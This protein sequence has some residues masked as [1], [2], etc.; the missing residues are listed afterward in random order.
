MFRLATQPQSIGKV[1]DSGLRLYMVSF[2]GV[3]GF[4]IGAGV[5][6]VIP[7]VVVEVVL[8]QE[9]TTENI[10]IGV[11]SFLLAFILLSI[12]LYGAI[13]VRM[14]GVT[15][16]I[17]IRFIQAIMI[18][19]KRLP[20]LLLVFVLYGIA[21]VL[22]TLLGAIVLF[23]IPAPIGLVVVAIPPTIVGLALYFGVP[24]ALLDDDSAIRSLIHSHRLVWGNWWRTAT[25]L[26]VP[27]IIYFALTAGLFTLYGTLIAIG[28]RSSPD[29]GGMVL[30]YGGQIFIN[31]A[32][33]P[34]IYAITIT[35]YHDL[36]LRK[37]GGD[38]AARIEKVAAKPR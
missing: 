7:S 19:L 14:G 20:R 6:G 9:I 31:A 1:L 11:F 10:G 30:L 5:I 28:G 33:V 13:F 35:Q 16:D 23:V 8:L 29:I 32:L 3:V 22:A 12:A 26:S 21:L 15:G 38:L 4:A 24:A 25:V 27:M 36:K 18:A 34:M 37:E 17:P 2:L